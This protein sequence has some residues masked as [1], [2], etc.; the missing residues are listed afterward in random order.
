[1][2]G[3]VLADAVS[4]VSSRHLRRTTNP[5]GEVSVKSVALP[6]EHGGWSLTAEPAILGLIVAWSWPGLAL[7]V[8]A[9]VAFVARTPLKLVLVD[10]W[11]GRWLD[12]SRLAATVAAVELAVLSLLVSY[13]LLGASSG[14]LLPLAV[15]APLV[16][17][18]LWFDMRSRSRR[19]LPELAGS[20]GIGSIATA[21]ALAGG[22]SNRVA[23]GLWVVIAARSI[24]AIPYVRTQILR[25]RS[26]PPH[27]WHSDAAQAIAVGVAFLG[28]INDLIPGAAA[29]VIGVIALINIAMVRSTPSRVVVIGIQQM[30]VGL[31]VVTVTAVAVL[32][33]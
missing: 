21:I 26:R 14:F 4:A 2:L 23:W 33:V 32:A 24:A 22:A 7:A 28:W 6:T 11:R 19:L 3:K 17:V 27:L 29:I 30:L 18:E 25:V 5:S 20:M 8:A 1:M 13:A 12:R 10:R 16:A 31:V 15:A 9:M